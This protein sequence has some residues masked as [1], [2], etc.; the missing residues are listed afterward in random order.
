MVV[1]IIRFSASK[2]AI[3]EVNSIT[4]LNELIQEKKKKKALI[5]SSNE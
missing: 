2:R 1:F 3:E 4:L 5:L